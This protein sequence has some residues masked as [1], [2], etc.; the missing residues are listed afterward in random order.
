[1]TSTP[2]L[3]TD[4]QLS[5]VEVLRGLS[6]EEIRQRL[7]DLDREAKALRTLLRAAVRMESGKTPRQL[8]AAP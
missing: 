3:T 4:R 1:M 5:A 6:A 7:A 8:R 2:T